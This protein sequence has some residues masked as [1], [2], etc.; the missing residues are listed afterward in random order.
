MLERM[1][2]RSV[3]LTVVVVAAATWF[4]GRPPAPHSIRA[5]A[6]PTP[7]SAVARGR[8][9]YERYGCQLCH[10]PD[11]KGGLANPNALRDAKVPSLIP[12]ADTYTAAE[13]AQVIRF[14]R[15]RIDK[16]DDKGAMPPFRMP[17][18]GNR[19]S[20]Q[21]VNDLVQY[22]MSLF[23]KGAKKKGWG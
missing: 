1:K 15:P 5:A 8:L 3:L 17:G 22:V 19:I 14:G 23:P 6:K 2:L 20:D 10:G 7:D 13:V 9:V 16:K 4:F 11:A 21:D 12:V 18:W